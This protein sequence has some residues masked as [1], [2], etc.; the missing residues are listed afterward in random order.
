MPLISEMV[1]PRSLDFANQRQVILLRDVKQL[2]WGQIRLQVK[3]LQGE[4][5]SRHLC[6]RIYKEFSKQQ[7]HRVFKYAKCGRKAWK[8]DTDVEKFLLKKLLDL[9]RASICT[10]STL[11]RELV[12]E[13]NVHLAC[14]TIRKVLIRN[15]YRWLPRAQKPKYSNQDMTA[16]LAFAEQV[17]AMSPAQLSRHLTM[18][19]DGVVLTVPPEDLA[20][21][22]NYCRI[23]DT[24][25]WR[26]AN[27]AA[28]PHLAGADV[29][30]KQVGS[31]RAVPMWGGIGPGGFGLVMFHSHKKVNQDEWAKAVD[32]GQLTKACK[33]ARPDRTQGPWRILADNESFL[34]APASRAAHRRA[35][36]DLW[37]IPPRSPDLNPVEKYWAWLR[38]RLRAMDVADLKA[39]RPP[40]KKTALK[41]RVRAL[42]Q[43]EGAKRVAINTFK[44]LRKTCAEVIEKRGAAART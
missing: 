21:R 13:R 26:K 19:M 12:R 6:M 33:D 1:H 4:R 5:P 44:T 15:G 37:H 32:K 43:T 39:K 11:Q 25:M 24:H 18:C 2:E 27:E 22:Q 41:A 23:G 16:R 42:L 31:A 40:I 8:V 7:G 30:N 20:Q 17:I 38:S 35:R 10:A 29:Y 34:S 3:N 14:S 36:V 9:R 28:Q